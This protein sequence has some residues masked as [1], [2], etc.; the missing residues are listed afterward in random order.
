MIAADS[1][2]VRRLGECARRNVLLGTSSWKYE[3]WL[4]QLYEPS[5]Y[6]Y[7]GK[8]ARNRFEAGCLEEY[9]LVFRT[10]CVDAGYYRFPDP[11]YLSKLVAQ[12]PAE[13]RFSFKATDEVTIRRFPK[14]PRHG[15]R[16][17]RV[18]EN[19][20]NASLFT[21]AFLGPMEPHRSNVGVIMFEF[22]RFHPGDFAR[23]RDFVE[24]LDGFLAGLPSGW[25]FGVEIRNASF[26]Q[27]EYFAMLRRH[28]VAHVF[29]AWTDM[30][31][32]PEQM[33]MPGSFT[34]D[35]FAA[36]FLLRRGRKYQ[37]AVDA[38][39]PYVE[40]R[41][42]D[43]VG[44]AAIRELSQREMRAPSYVFVNNRFEGNALLTIAAALG[45]ELI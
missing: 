23:G 7:R 6:L 18:N 19:F 2:F 37:E 30:P 21:E 11:G 39:S 1:D 32:I 40:I 24:A 29:N 22:S 15:D 31:T 26:L 13:F 3:G 12:V 5:K 25:Q 43:P 14:Q 45:V 38:F 36:R 27:P 8:L 44:C 41:D 9:A 33:A 20:L 4:G 35:F 10:V 16:V 34:A 28:G 42:P 17:G